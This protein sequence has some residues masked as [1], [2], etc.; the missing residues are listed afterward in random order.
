MEGPK[1]K[2][3]K[4]CALSAAC[5][6]V[7]SPGELFLV[8]CLDCGATFVDVTEPDGDVQLHEVPNWNCCWTTSVA[9]RRLD[10]EQDEWIELLNETKCPKCACR[11]LRPLTF[12]FKKV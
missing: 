11:S 10:G 7:S 6:A 5:V 8:Q 9:L 3:C 2:T 4:A 1:E 12:L